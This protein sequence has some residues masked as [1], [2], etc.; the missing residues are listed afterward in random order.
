MSKSKKKG[1]KKVSKTTSNNSLLYLGAI[2]GLSLLAMIP[3]FSGG[4]LNYD[5]ELYI[6]QNPF[7]QN[8]EIGKL[9]TE[10]YANQYS[11]LAMLLMALQ[12][13]LGF[14][15]GA[16]KTISVLL[17]LGNTAL[18]FFIIKK[19]F[20]KLEW[21]ALVAVL[22]SLCP[23]QME[24]V[25]WLAASM[26][27]GTYALFFLGTIWL[28]LKYLDKEEKHY[29][30]GAF[31]LFLAAC[32]CKEQA[33][34]LA[35]SLLAIDYLKKRSIFS[36]KVLIEKIPFFVLALIFGVLTLKASESFEVKQVIYDYGLGE[37]LLFAA[38]TLGY[39][40]VKMIIPVNLSFFYTY[41]IQGAIP[42][43]Y[44]LYLLVFLG[45]LGLFVQAIRNNN[46]VLIF[47][48]L[49]FGINIGLTIFTQVLSVR[50]VIMAD[51]YI[52]IPAIGWFIALAFFIEKIIVPR[53][54][55]QSF[56][57][58]TGIL[59]IIMAALS[60]Q[61]AKVWNNSISLFSDVIEKEAY[62]D[63]INPYLALPYN[64]RGIA[65]KRDKKIAE[66]MQDFEAAIKAN[67]KYASGYLN[68]G[69]IY[70]DQKKNDAAL[71]DYTKALSLEPKNE[72]ALSA[73][74]A[75]YARRG[76]LE[77]ALQD[78]NAAIKI[79]PYFLDALGNRALLLMNLN[80]HKE[81]IDDFSTA[82]KYN[83]QDHAS[84]SARGICYSRLGQYDKC[85]Q[86]QTS[87]L[88][89]RPNQGAYYLNRS[90]AHRDKGDKVKAQQDAQKAQQLGTQVGA[91][92]LDSIR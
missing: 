85:I 7:I 71:A 20:G 73:R 26:K 13:K 75:I 12:Y 41:P 31:A 40:F 84:Y 51:R 33:V 53:A 29:L 11:P 82:L 24:S 27:I 42:L 65:L 62:A 6:A 67:P 36:A 60:F 68:R 74:A 72:R 88:R 83:N 1:Q 70:F 48:L 89:I 37:R 61:R 77:R 28:Y 54:G 14:G 8:F 56:L 2:L 10:F 19:L 3:I 15:I 87:A 4:I 57:Y 17:H 59:A 35:P 32:L 86:D 78:V 64:N 52:Y 16:L 30:F 25:A 38:Y 55:K 46:R 92:Y 34:A 69:N 47:A 43:Y 50:D 63:K 81:A 58:A 91:D 23:L 76:E 22:F 5:D 21:A 9:F 90:V 18:V 45:V 39:Y 79:D 66:A 49:F 44:Y 80:R